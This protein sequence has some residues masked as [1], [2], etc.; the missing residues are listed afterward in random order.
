MRKSKLELTE[1]DRFKLEEGYKNGASHQF[2]TRCKA[3]LLKSEGKTG[4]Q[5]K[6]IL[7]VSLPSI[8]TWIANFKSEGIK[9][10]ETRPGQGRKPIMDSTDELVV[11]KAIEEDRQSL[12]KAKEAWQNATGK[13]ASDSTFRRFLEVLVQDIDV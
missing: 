10:L 13:E 6:D 9:G 12:S 1:S 2:R 3:V 11:Q 8:Y 7:D 5:I 4:E